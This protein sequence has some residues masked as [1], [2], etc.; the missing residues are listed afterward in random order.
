M[1][2]LLA[3]VAPTAG[4]GAPRWTA[5]EDTSVKAKEHLEQ[6][7]RAEDP[8]AEPL[9]YTIEGLPMGAKADVRDGS[10][11]V[12]WTPG[13]N[14]VGTYELTL[15]A[16][17]PHGAL[18]EKKVKL[19]VEED[20]NNF[21][22]PGI[23][24]ALF[25]PSDKPPDSAMTG[26][27]SGKIGIFQ[28]AR[29]EFCVWCYVHRSDKRGPAIGKT[30]IAFDLMASTEASSS[31]LFNAVLGFNLSFEKNPARRFL[32]PFFGAETGI[33]YQKVTETLGM[34]TPYAGAHLWSS[35]NF[36]V[37]LKAG[38]LIPFS[39]YR[40]EQIVGLRAGLGFNLA[41]W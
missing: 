5:A 3:Q 4:N 12:D 20:V 8:E 33:W 19:T 30:Y 38:V 22:M 26:P 29:V 17:D 13:D 41:F 16:A 25:V 18:V 40:L 14:D 35:G 15:K 39:S 23:E 34:A 21:V 24:Y 10:V 31:A 11:I 36:D 37:T 1:A 7:Y 2:P 32:I 28:G 6:S 27:G 9:T